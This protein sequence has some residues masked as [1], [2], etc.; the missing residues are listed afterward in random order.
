VS[1]RR[2]EDGVEA[3]SDDESRA[4]ASEGAPGDPPGEY[5]PV[6]SVDTGAIALI[7][8]GD[9]R[10]AL[11]SVSGGISVLAPD[12]ADDA[13]FGVEGRPRGLAIGSLVYVAVDD[14][15]C[16]Y[17]FDGA[18]RWETPLDG[19][20]ALCWVP[21]CSR[22]VA[23]TDAGAFVLL[24]AADGSERG[25]IDRTH[26]DVSEAV[27][28]AGRDDEFLAGESWY[29][30][31][32]GADGDRRGEAM[33]D[34]TI[35]G[36]GLLDGA[37]V[38]SLHG[39]RVVGVDAADG[40]TRWSRDL[41]VEWL[42]PRGA[43]GLYAATDRGIVRITGD[44]DVT[45]VGVVAGADAQVAIS[46]DGRLACRIDGRTAEVLRPRASLAGVD[47]ELTPASLRA[48]EELSVTVESRGGAASGTVRVSADGASFSPGSRRVSV[49]A[50]ER[51]EIG[52]AL[53]EPTASRVAVTAVFDPAAPDG[54]PT[55]AD[56]TLSVPA[57]TPTP[58]VD[59]RV[60]EVT[61][62]TATVEVTVRT[63]D[64][65]E[66]PG[67]AVSPG[68]ADVAP[69][70][71]RS[72]ASRT[73]A[74]PLGTD[75]VTVTTDDGASVDAAVSVPATPLSASVEGRDGFVDVTLEN[76]AGVRVDGDVRVTGDPLP[77]PVER[78]V[79]L[80]PGA[81]LT[82]AIP[83][84]RTGA[85][86]VSV[87]AGAVDTT[88]AVSLDRAALPPTDGTATRGRPRGDRTATDWPTD[89]DAGVGASGTAPRDAPATP[90][91]DRE[92][93]APDPDPPRRPAGSDAGD[94]PA[95]APTDP[96]DR[97][98]ADG[99]VGSTTADGSPPEPAGRPAPSGTDA[100][101]PVTG[102]DPIGLARSLESETANEGHAVEETLTVENR[103][104]E[105]QS[106]TLR[107]DEAEATVELRP[108]AE[109]T[110]S[111]YHAGWDADSI[112]VPAVTARADGS[113]ATAPSASIPID[114]APVVVR[115]AL[116]VRATTTDVR[117]DVFNDLDTTCSV[118]E[119]GSKG[120]SNSVTFEGF[121]VAPGAEARRETSYRGTPAER[122]ALTFVRIDRRRRPLPTLAAVNDSAAPPVSV[123]VDSVDTLGDRDT[124]VVLRVRNEGAAPL[125]VDVE[126]TGTAPDEYLYS[127]ERFAGLGPGE[128]TTHRVECVADGDRIELPVALDT[129]PTG[130]A[131]DPQSTTVTVSGDRTAD[132]D[133]WRVDADG[134]TDAPAL[135]ATL[136]TPLNVGST[137]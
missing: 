109:A 63:P 28:L 4:A 9:D 54:E 77:T 65:S 30:T 22:V 33:L 126:A 31:G 11:G 84:A 38:A 12:A 106:V 125:D 135:P 52:F 127:P 104:S 112:E 68:D 79:S 44:G 20:T 2:P 40:T 87:D 46:A 102:G 66:L 58:E 108:G 116:S 81:R 26:A 57:S 130:D 19:V 73:L 92:P 86:E 17:G 103:S 124:N 39:D 101:A 37:A 137:D 3:A 119:V 133:A 121:D 136:S 23:A 47:L 1:G 49:A 71:G 8:A 129:T 72:S 36:V 6:R 94:R 78:P 32:F 64:G 111:R 113:E 85:G 42:A 131:D 69:D 5:V 41:G 14:R 100:D 128:S 80:A 97:P 99:S 70:P 93:A 107:S 56:A 51:A 62:N 95:D 18:R 61:G 25:R 90:P 74:V 117:L 123:A 75:R 45:D 122:P 110:A 76:D 134:G 48:G 29:L 114:P 13:Q 132:A 118:L 83:A 24:D 98:P 10:L 55:A 59:A 120:F 89:P 15:V 27:L 105:P 115:P 67:F 16:G 91:S 88:T 35:T 21:G 43:D 50:G 82:L 34:G 60:L 7:A 53:A 96:D